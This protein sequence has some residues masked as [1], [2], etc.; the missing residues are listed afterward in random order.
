MCWLGAIN[1]LFVAL[2][3]LFAYT[4]TE[5]STSRAEQ[6]ALATKY[7]ILA[8]EHATQTKQI[9]D[10]REAMHQELQEKEEHHLKQRQEEVRL[11]TEK[12]Q[13]AVSFKVHS[14]VIAYRRRRV[15][16]GPPSYE[17]T[18]VRGS[19]LALISDL[20]RLNIERNKC[21]RDDDDYRRPIG[22]ND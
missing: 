14:E 13:E 15:V 9:G 7:E 10:L 2:L 5:I 21:R 16:D 3:A 20:K 6:A 11:A 4:A 12:M 1:A 8:A 18:A 17:R 22:R 19:D